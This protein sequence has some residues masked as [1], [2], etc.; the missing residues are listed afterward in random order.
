[1]STINIP[2]TVILE[3]QRKAYEFKDQLK[4]KEEAVELAKKKY[5]QA[6]SD[7]AYAAKQL[8]E[9]LDF[10]QECNTD[11]LDHAD[12]WHEELG[13]NRDELLKLEISVMI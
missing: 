8:R 1:M 3:M 13:F 10:L 6:M 11:A 9:T 2:E 12:T 7:H 4:H 5:H